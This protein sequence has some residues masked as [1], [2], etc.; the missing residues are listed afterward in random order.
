MKKLP[1]ASSATPTLQKQKVGGGHLVRQ[2][3][4]F[5]VINKLVG[6]LLKEIATN[7]NVIM[8]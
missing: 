7:L 8:N 6:F 3:K 5:L 4:L 1:F 2:S